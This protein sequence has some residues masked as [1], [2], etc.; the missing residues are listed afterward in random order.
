MDTLIVTFFV[1]VPDRPAAV[2]WYRDMLDLAHTRADDYG[3]EFRLTDSANLRLTA[4]PG[5]EPSP[6]PC[7]AWQVPDLTSAAAALRAKDIRFEVYEG[8]GQDADGI[9]TAP[10]DGRRLAF[11]KDLA[12]NVLMLNERP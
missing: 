11:F 1:Q 2:A 5:Y 4:I 12:G 6:H 8:M 3:D 7:V 9:W 10:D